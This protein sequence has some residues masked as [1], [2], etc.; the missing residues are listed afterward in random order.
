MIKLI[1]SDMDGTLLDGNG[2]ISPYNVEMINEAKKRG[3]HFVIASG[4]AYTDIIPVTQQ[5]GVECACVTGN[6]AE[7]ID[8]KGKL[9]SSCYLGAKEAIEVID[10]LK[11]LDIKFMIYTTDN[12][13]SIEAVEN[14][15]DAFIQRSLHKDKTQTYEEV[16]ERLITRHSIFRM[17]EVEDYPSLLPTK[18]I[19]KIE[20]FDIDVRKIEEA[21]KRLSAL[22][23]VAYLSSFPDNVEITHLDATKGKILLKA[24]TL[25]GIKEEEVMVLGD[26]FNDLSMFELF[27]NSV[28]MAN[29]EEEVKK[30][31]KYRTEA[32]YEDGVG[33][34]IKRWVLE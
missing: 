28:V 22:G 29:G 17:E 14:V 24:A 9:I 33:K 10:I 21:K 12:R 15:Q 5:H 26:S 34:A 6:G 27:E 18:R 32:Y 13:Y 11:A 4:R 16:K 3:I 23:N 1:A 25:L 2:G 8:E 31:A 30:V 7:Y 20:A 19:I